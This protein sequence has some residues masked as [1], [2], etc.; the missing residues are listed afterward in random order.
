MFKEYYGFI[1]NPFD[2][3]SISEKDAFISIDHKQATDRLKF[4]I[5]HRGIGLITAMPG[6]GKTFALRCFAKSLDSNLYE[7]AYI[8][9]STVSIIEFYRQ[10]C[11][12]LGIEPLYRKYAMFR[13]I[14]AKLYYLF[15][16][17]RRPFVLILDEANELSL[18][19]LKDLKMLLNHDYDSKYCF[20][21]I[22]AGEPHLNYELDKS[23]HAALR[24]RITVHYNYIGL[25]D[26]ETEQYLL[27][28]IRL[29][30]ASESILG[31]G[32]LAAFIGYSHGCPRLLDNLMNEAL[33]LGAQQQKPSLDAEIMMAAVNSLML[34]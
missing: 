8:S 11:I 27:H 6:Y 29:A 31:E 13:E 17:K 28:K 21:L 26:Q 1:K 34:S 22:L 14:Q 24:Q 7:I 19:I 30:G 16:E 32:T 20:T 25:S 2:K 4:L 33:I 9:L 10:F 18:I 3:Q 5:N 15:K 12:A 23:S